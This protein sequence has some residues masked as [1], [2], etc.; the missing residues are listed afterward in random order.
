MT[1]ILVT[2]ATGT[3]GKPTVAGLRAAGY[4]VR[5]LSRK[6]GADL[7]TGDLVSGAGIPE[8]IRGVDTVLHLSTG[9]G[10]IRATETLLAAATAA[11]VAHLVVISI[12]GIDGIRLQYYKDKV[13]IE[14]LVAESSVPYTI[15]R[16]TQ[17]HS[18]VVGIFAAQ[19]FSPILFAPSFSMQPIAVEEVA[20]RLIELAGSDAAGRVLDIGGP[21]QRTLRDLGGAWARASHSRRPIWPLSIPGRMFAGFASGVG[22]VPGTPFGTGT[23]EEYLAA[24]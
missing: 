15:L 11:K 18:F 16:A 24:R 7:V 9:K 19:R 20:A 22:M 5:A 21:A 10:D 13:V 3:L 23:F 2:G 4:E 12:V 1:T 8:A 6:T 14:R 17:F